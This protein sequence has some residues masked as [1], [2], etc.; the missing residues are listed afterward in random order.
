MVTHTLT[1]RKLTRPPNV[2]PH[3]PRA[4]APLQTPRSTLNANKLVSAPFSCLLVPLATLLH[5]LLLAA[6]L[7][8]R[9][10]HLLAP[11]PMRVAASRP[12]LVQ[13]VAQLRVRLGPLLPALTPRVCFPNSRSAAQHADSYSMHSDSSAAGSSSNPTGSAGASS[14]ASSSSSSAFAAPTNSVQMG[15]SAAGALGL[16][17]A[18]IAL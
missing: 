3:A 12:A 14:G 8:P 18:A 9:L 11:P 17:V 16:L 1:P 10:M 4:M 15:A 6:A 2:P 13:R 7:V 5:P